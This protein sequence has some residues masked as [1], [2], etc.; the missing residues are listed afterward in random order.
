MDIAETQLRSWA[1]GIVRYDCHR[2]RLWLADQRVHHGLTG[3]LLAAAGVAGLASRRMAGLATLE[4]ALLGT[5]LMADDW[6]DRSVWLAREHAP[7]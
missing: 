5:A 3:A 6:H 4:L 2:R 1:R 7:C